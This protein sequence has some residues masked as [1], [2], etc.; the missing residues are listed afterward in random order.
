MSMRY[1][2]LAACGFLL[3]SM[4]AGA[5]V[6]PAHAQERG[7]VYGQDKDVLPDTPV[8]VRSSDYDIAPA[9]QDDIE[10]GIDDSEE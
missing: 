1:Y 9:V 10:A 3:A 5:W 4:A 8:H 2:R 6:L 7:V